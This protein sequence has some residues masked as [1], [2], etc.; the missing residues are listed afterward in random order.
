MERIQISQPESAAE[1]VE[2]AAKTLCEGGLVGFPTET[3]YGIAARADHDQAMEKLSGL[4][5]EPGLEQPWTLHLANARAAEQLLG[6]LPGLVRYW[7]SRM[8]PGPVTIMLELSDQLAADPD[9]PAGPDT[10]RDRIVRGGVISLRCPDHP[11]ARAMLDAVPHVVIAAGA[12]KNG[13]LPVTPEDALSQVGDSLDLLLE[14]G[15]T[16]YARPSTVIRVG[17]A[18]R[19]DD[20]FVV[21]EGVYSER[22]IRKMLKIN[23]LFVCTGN[24]CRSPMSEIMARTLLSQRHQVRV[25]QLPELG[26]EIGSAGVY[27]QGCVPA[28]LP[29]QEAVKR[30]GLDLSEHRSRGL[31]TEM[32]HQADLVFCMTRSHQDAILRQIPE[33]SD[34]VHLLSSEA[35]IADPYGSDVESYATCLNQ[36]KTAL[37]RRIEEFSL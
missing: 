22:F 35:E 18:G 33:A 29:A 6:R 13:S 7:F 19:P 5:G 36:I 16:R 32:I 27:G 23:I 3:V 2:V 20:V 37:E 4:L 26:I 24:T 8:W 11:V 12:S 31:T 14:D 34:K 17:A 9:W 30:L 28:S 1:A 25:Q 21:R 10:M 15:Q